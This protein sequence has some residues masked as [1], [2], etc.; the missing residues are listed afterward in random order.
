MGFRDTGAGQTFPNPNANK[1]DRGLARSPTPKNANL[2]LLNIFEIKC[3]G[4]CEWW[5]G[6]ETNCCGVERHLWL[7]VEDGGLFE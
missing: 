1:L 7:T 2:R 4:G 5:C 3:P 6:T